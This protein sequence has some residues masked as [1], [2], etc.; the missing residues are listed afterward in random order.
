VPLSETV[1]LTCPKC[2]GS[3]DY[4]FIPGASFSAIRLG[5]SRYMR[6]PLCHKFAVFRMRDAPAAGPPPSGTPP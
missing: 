2:G 4:E 1:R 6:C 3:F 5:T